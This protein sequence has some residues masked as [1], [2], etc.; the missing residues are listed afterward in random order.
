MV[1]FGGFCMQGL[2]AGMTDYS[3]QS[4]SEIAYDINCWLDYTKKVRI[5]LNDNLNRS[6]ESG[7][8]EKVSTDFQ[9][10]F[11]SSLMF[12]KTIEKDLSIIKD[13]MDSNAIT[14]REIKL[15]MNIGNKSFEYNREYGKTYHAKE[16]WKDY[17]DSNFRIVEELY[18]EGRQ[19][20]IDLEDAQNAAYRLRDYMQR[21]N[22]NAININGIISNSQLQINTINSNQSNSSQTSFP[23]EE[24]KKLISI[25]EQNHDALSKE[26]KQNSEKFFEAFEILTE[27]VKTSCN[28]TIPKLLIDNLTKH[29][30]GVATTPIISKIITFIQSIP[31]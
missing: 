29:M 13:A 6:K 16:D 3:I 19:Y 7:Y 5:K 9:M 2:I 30:I 22:S 18:N 24:I 12:C 17:E 14:G 11:Q 20:F 26:L 25:I 21:P 15:L 1:S 27:E 31:I 4:L 28:P 10:T 8:W 23:K